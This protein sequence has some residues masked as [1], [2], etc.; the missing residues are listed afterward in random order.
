MHLINI[1]WDEYFREAFYSMDMKGC[2]PARVAQEHKGRYIL[3][4]ETGDLT[5]ELSGRFVHTADARSQFPAVG[6][7]VV[8]QPV[9]SGRRGVIHAV[10]PRRSY[11][12]RKAVLA[13]GPKYGPGRT[14]EQILSANVDIAFLISGLDEEFNL[15]RIERYLT[16]AWEGGVTPVILLNKADLRDNLEDL[17]QEVEAVAM[18]VP[19]HAIS[20]LENEGLEVIDDLLGPGR[21]AV[22]L[23]SSGVGKSSIINCLLNEERQAIFEVSDFKSRGRHTTTLREMIILPSGGIVIDTPGIREIQLW[24]DENGLSTSFDDIEAFA[25]ECRFRDCHHKD[26][27]GCAVRRA[28][29]DGRLDDSRLLNYFKL[30]K[31]LHHLARRRDT[32]AQQ[33]E[34][35]K[36][37]EIAKKIR[38]FKKGRY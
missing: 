19:I 33:I 34:K 27:P 17:I 31:E 6:D 18:A 36:W 5:A 37:K 2:V 3:L 29:A 8:M 9:D 32:R 21:T 28:V 10:L 26:E 22:F 11:L 38:G 16:V 35:A 7:W 23:G 15:R 20:A 13:G 1:G 14:E 12:S 4:G 25:A 30:Q 24:T